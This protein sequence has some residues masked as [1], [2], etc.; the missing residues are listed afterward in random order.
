[1]RHQYFVTGIGTDIG[2]TISSAVLVE[3]FKASYFK[4]IQS[5]DLQNSDTMKI[6]ALSKELKQAY[7][8]RYALKLAASPDKS[9]DLENI[10]IDI[11]QIVMPKTT[12]NLIIEGAGGLFVPINEDHFIIDVIKKLNLP[13]ILVIKDYLGC[14]NHALLSISAI[15]KYN[16]NLAYVV[17]NSSFD[18][19][20]KNIITKHLPKGVSIID[21]PFLEEISKETIT[22]TAKNLKIYTL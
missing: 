11:E 8:E 2:K 3:Y 13:V 17:F 9:A 1:M 21:I 22:K 19:A 20:T 4:P 16:V 14:I 12:E 5:G 15:E 18:K 6:C 7:R 10:K